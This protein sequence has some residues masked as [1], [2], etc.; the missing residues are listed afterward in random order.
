MKTTKLA[1]D[2]DMIRITFRFFLI[3]MITIVSFAP[4]IDRIYLNDGS[5]Y[6]DIY[7]FIWIVILGYISKRIIETK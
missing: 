2:I 6:Y 4:A 3:Y 7:C 5:V 1:R